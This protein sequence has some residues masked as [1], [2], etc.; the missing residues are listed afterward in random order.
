MTTSVPMKPLF[1]LKLRSRRSEAQQSEIDKTKLDFAR[2]RSNAR[3][4]KGTEISPGT[5][6][7]DEDV[8][9]GL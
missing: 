4:P 6:K 2:R 9:K 7:D 1:A 8:K 3:G 5:E